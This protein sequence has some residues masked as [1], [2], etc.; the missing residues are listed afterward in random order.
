LR[1]ATVI[2]WP[3]S[4]S[5]SPLIHG[6]WLK[7]YGISG[8]YER[9]PVRPD[10]LPAFV[11][12]VRRGELVGGNVTVP[13]KEAVLALVDELDDVG[14]AIGA[15][16]TLW[17]DS[18]RVFATNTDAHGFLANLN[19]AHPD[20]RGTPG[21]PLVIGAGGAARAV[22]F[23]LSQAGC[24]H[25]RI[26]NRTPERAHELA[27]HFGAGIQVVD[28]QDRAGRLADVSLLVNT[29]TQ[30]MAANPPLDLPLSG[31]APAAIVYDLVYVPLRTPL[32]AA[33]ESQGNR[34]LGGLGMLLH[35]AVVGFERWFGRKPEVTDG[36]FKLVAADIEGH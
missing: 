25:I 6:Y 10:E 7:R 23:A 11:D 13:H 17:T 1:K 33:A 28:W 21:T 4:H 31:L 30:G 3:I 9:R 2:G 34:T 29:T 22:I 35:Q 16:N 24:E 5:R 14:R 12:L 32:L 26:A 36:L 19:D 18:G 27:S 15:A 20:W 8:S